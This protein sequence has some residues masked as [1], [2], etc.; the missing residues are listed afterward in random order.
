MRKSCD[1]VGH[2]WR[3]EDRNGSCWR[4]CIFCGQ[5]SLVEE[6]EIEKF[7]RLEDES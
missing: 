1:A 6:G 2:V 3:Y 4:V 5:L 7:R